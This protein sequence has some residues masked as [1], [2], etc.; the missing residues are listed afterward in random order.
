MANQSYQDNSYDERLVKAR[1][2]VTQNE[3]ASTADV[4]AALEA[5]EFRFEI[6]E[7]VAAVAGEGGGDGLEEVLVGEEVIYETPRQPF[8]RPRPAPRTAPPRRH[9]HVPP[10][11]LW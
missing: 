1:V 11:M 10:D 2:C 8:S 9:Q 3:G 4:Q 6:S 5:G 7:G